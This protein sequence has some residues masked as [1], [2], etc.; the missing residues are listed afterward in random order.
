MSHSQIEEK[1]AVEAGYWQLYR[2]N[3]TLK[4]EGKNPFSL[5]SKEPTADYQEF[6]TSET[7]YTSLKKMFP[8]FVD[9]LFAQSEAEAKERLEYYKKLAED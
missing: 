5:D 1:R 2:F 6:I 9:K 3:P 8:Q 7:R 4:A